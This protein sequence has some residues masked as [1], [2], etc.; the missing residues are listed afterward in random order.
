M[1]LH[2]GTLMGPGQLMYRLHSHGQFL[3]IK[4]IV[5]SRKPSFTML[6]SILLYSLC[7]APSTLEGGY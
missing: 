2:D 3:V 1:G 6:L 5:R 7:N 4:A